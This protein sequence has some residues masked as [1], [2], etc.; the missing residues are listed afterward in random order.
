MW[1]SLY[2]PPDTFDNTTVVGAAN[3]VPPVLPV[4]PVP[5]GSRVTDL[6]KAIAQAR[7]WLDNAVHDVANMIFGPWENPV[8]AKRFDL[9]FGNPREMDRIRWVFMHYY[10]ADEVMYRRGYASHLII[11]YTN[12]NTDQ[13]AQTDPIPP[14]D[15]VTHL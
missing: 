2:N 5:I 13:Y 7:I 9:W 8:I 10:G 15:W 6:L 14:D 3:V 4:P 1:S 12:G 11:E